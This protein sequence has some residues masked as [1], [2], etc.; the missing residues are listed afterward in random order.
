MNDISTCHALPVKTQT[1]SRKQKKVIP[2]NIIV[3]FSNRKTK[4]KVIENDRNLKDYNESRA[5][6][7]GI[8][9]HLTKKN[10]D[11]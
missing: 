7:V 1:K 9:E 5:V 3:R 6:K 10:A 2:G 8:N 4:D 11:V